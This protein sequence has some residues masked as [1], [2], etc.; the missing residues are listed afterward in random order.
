LGFYL[1]DTF[2]LLK[3]LG[4]GQIGVFVLE[5]RFPKNAGIS[6]NLKKSKPLNKHYLN[7][8]FLS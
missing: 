2:K 3:S 6:K 4:R 1:L 8:R 7:T 5:I